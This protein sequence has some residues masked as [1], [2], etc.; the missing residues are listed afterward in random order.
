MLV[1]WG[2]VWMELWG[3]LGVFC[4]S[5]YVR[6]RNHSTGLDVSGYWNNDPTHCHNDNSNN[7]ARNNRSNNLRI[8]KKNH[9]ARNNN[10]NK[11]DPARNNR[12]G[13]SWSKKNHPAHNNNDNKN[14]DNL[15][16]NP[17]SWENRFKIL[18]CLS[19]FFLC[20]SDLYILSLFNWMC[21]NS[22]MFTLT[23]IRLFFV[24]PPR[25]SAFKWTVS[26]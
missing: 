1:Y 26:S 10:D 2:V 4:S 8:R 24:Q 16:Q 19:I 11:N 22:T 20:L 15:P 13:N 5:T 12:W 3:I 25:V 9:S 6:V 7:P 14:N 17:S 18:I 21:Q 23:G